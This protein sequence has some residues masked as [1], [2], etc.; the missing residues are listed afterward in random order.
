MTFGRS[1]GQVTA[2]TQQVG[3][4]A[5][6]AGSTLLKARLACYTMFGSYNTFTSVQQAPPNTLL[7]ISWR[8]SGN[9]PELVSTS[10]W[11]DSTW[12]VAGPGELDVFDRWT[13]FN[14]S[15][16]PTEMYVQHVYANHIEADYPLYES[17]AYSLGLSINFL[18]AGFWDNVTTYLSYELSYWYD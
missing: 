1:F 9:S 6:P 3:L 16:A 15:Q 14:D 12:Y 4:A 7:G 13:A 10:N 8:P 18:G 17:G 5:F 2:A 11:T